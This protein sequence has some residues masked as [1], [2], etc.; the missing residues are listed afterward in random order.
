M[1]E[2][3]LYAFCFVN[4]CTPLSIKSWVG[5]LGR[6]V[7]STGSDKSSSDVAAPTL[8]TGLPDL[9][10]VRSLFVFVPTVLLLAF[11][12]EKSFERLDDS[13]SWLSVFKLQ[14]ANR[15]QSIYSKKEVAQ[16]FTL[17]KKK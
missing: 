15:D 14:M 2:I 11:S 9:L 17:K 12:T 16:L 8:R 3:G 13:C 6:F 10:N 7:G 1:K 5:F 4:G